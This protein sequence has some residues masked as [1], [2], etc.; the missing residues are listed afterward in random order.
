MRSAAEIQFRLRQE[1]ANL[2]LLWRQPVFHG[3][4]PG[5]LS[6]PNGNEVA[7]ELRGTRYAQDVENIA[8][9][10]LAHRF[11]IL[12]LEISTG[13]EI[14]WR[15]DY[16]HG[17]SSE[18]VY[19][20]R[21]PYLNFEAVG[22]HK[23][24]WELNRHQHLV[25]LA[26]AFLITKDRKFLVEIE[27]QLASWHGQNPFQKGI[28][29]ASAL[30][31]AFR[32]LSWI[33]V[34]HLVGG[35]LTATTRQG[36]LTGL[37]QHGLHLSENLSVYFSPN[38]HLLGEAVVLYAIATLFPAF[39]GAT[40]WR[41]RSRAIVVDQLTFQVRPDGSHF[42]QSSYYHVYAVDFFLLFLV[43]DGNSPETEETLGRMGS[44]LEALLGQSG[45]IDFWG[46]DDGGRL[47]HPYGPRN[48]FGRATL[49]TLGLKL[50]RPDWVRSRED[51]AEQAGW[52]L[53]VDALR[54]PEADGRSSALRAKKFSDSGAVFLA[55]DNFALQ[56]DC[57]PFG[58]GGA[59]HS[60]SDTLA[61][62]L[63]YR[64]QSVVLDPGTYTYISDVDQRNWF[65]G[66]VAHN[67]VWVDG[68]DQAKPVT[69]FRWAD[70]PH[71]EL[72][73]FEPSQTG[74]LVVASCRYG[75]IRHTRSV[76]VAEAEVIV[77]DE[78]NA[79][80][81]EHLCEQSWHFGA[82]RHPD[83]SFTASAPLEERESWFSPAYGVKV[84]GSAA[85]ATVR[86]AMPI[87]IAARFSQGAGR[88]ITV[89]EANE[90]L[91]AARRGQS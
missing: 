5:Q 82:T 31:V 42:E 34:Y 91:E 15:R 56:M 4:G 13:D 81:G 17:K 79:P 11:P 23:L 30:E 83:L 26:Q 73:R 87:R 90:L 54:T 72:Q 76:L 14:D 22:D 50:D 36:L 8:H 67:T 64:G 19:F 57:G 59:G 9:K 40:G 16:L 44:Y 45:E 75:E 7:D 12:G 63:R 68:Q 33:W 49:A 70:L 20:K 35:E 77:V 53:G 74:G 2:V 37:Y 89:E 69:P 61:I 29:W 27:G 46:D 47:F 65:R 55:N 24:V 41:Q 66:S 85:V 51:R 80:A 32:A 38:T 62:T 78:V 39:H 48:R 28:N 10:L 25:L 84:R 58:Y 43:L 88:P 1:I 71:V 3:S 21:V 86:G 6:L 18:A 52:W 60:H